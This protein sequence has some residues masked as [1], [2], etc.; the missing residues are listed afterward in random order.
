M[1]IYGSH[2]ARFLYRNRCNITYISW[3]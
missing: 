1:D 2:L 3:V